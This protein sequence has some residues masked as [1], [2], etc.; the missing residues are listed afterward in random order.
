M[1]VGFIYEG[2]TDIPVL[3]AVVDAVLGP[4]YEARF[5]QPERDALGGLT[6]WTEVK[7]WCER[8]GDALSDLLTWTSIDL[9]I[10]QIDA[11]VR[12]EVRARTTA[13]L[14]ATV[15]GWLGHGARD[16][17][18]V[19]VI[20][21]QAIEAW[22]LAAHVA[23]SPQLEQQAHPARQ[24]VRH[25]LLSGAAD[26]RPIKDRARYE[27][28]SVKLTE[29][30]AELRDVLPELDRFVSKLELAAIRLGRPVAPPAQAE[31]QRRGKKRHG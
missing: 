20:P 5:I 24:L 30:V 26:G 18:L 19:I 1:V 21:A 25:H 16:P 12:T 7:K 17:R 11:D 8:S 27:A 14:C 29:R 28:L 13:D 3:Q 2:V 15:K 23:P 22:L 10:L 6:G 9:L 31:K 4:D